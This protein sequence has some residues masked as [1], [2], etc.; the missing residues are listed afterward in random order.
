[1]AITFWG[2]SMNNAVIRERTLLG[3]GLGLAAMTGFVTSQAVPRFHD[4]FQSFGAELPWLTLLSLKFYPAL[5]ALPL[6]VLAVWL[7]WPRKEKRGQVALITGVAIFVV[8][9]LLLAAV[10]YLPILRLGS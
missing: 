2:G 7:A 1:M 6:L 9:P 3:V 4:V 8:V 5:L 10:M